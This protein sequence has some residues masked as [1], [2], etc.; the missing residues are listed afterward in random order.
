[1]LYRKFDC[2]LIYK[3]FMH[4]KYGS[5]DN[6]REAAQLGTQELT[7]WKKAHIVPRKGES[8]PVDSDIYCAL[9]ECLKR[10]FLEK[11]AY[12][13]SEFDAVA[14]GDVEHYRP[15]RGVTEDLNHPGYYWLTYCESNLMPSCQK[16]NQGKGKRNHFPISGL[17]AAQ[18]EHD[19]R[20]EKPLLL[21][22]YEECDC[23]SDAC[24]VSYV[25]EYSGWEVLATGRVEGL[26]DRGKESVKLYDLN[27]KSL[28]RRRRRNQVQA[29][30]ALRLAA[31]TPPALAAEWMMLFS[32][33][34]E[35]ASAVRAACKAWITHY[36]KQL[37]DATARGG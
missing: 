33:D 16:C 5:F 1:M 4:R 12:C 7:E 10:Y 13:E 2:D 21:N 28:V 31:V 30:K 11:C 18:P 20:L 14:W 34:Q 9:K 37:D 35:H 24:H 36:K 25:F 3:S 17:R 8:L 6:W 29:M 15:K 19:I 26:T 27:R 23:G 32:E 22:P